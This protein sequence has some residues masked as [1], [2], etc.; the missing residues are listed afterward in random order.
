MSDARIMDL[1]VQ[2][3]GFDHTGARQ[4]GA[5]FLGATPEPLPEV[6]DFVIGAKG[7]EE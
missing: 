6:V 4:L 1:L 3:G 7:F 2:V 5:D